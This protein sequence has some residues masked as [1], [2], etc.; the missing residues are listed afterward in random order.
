MSGLNHRRTVNLAGSVPEGNNTGTPGGGG[1]QAS[2]PTA[3]P[4]APPYPEG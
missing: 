2:G 3:A 1:T 4:A